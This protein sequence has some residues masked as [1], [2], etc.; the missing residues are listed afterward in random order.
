[1][2]N[3]RKFSE[4]IALHT[5][6]QAEETAR[7]EQIMKEVSDATA[8]VA[9]DRSSSKNTLRINTQTLG[10]FRGGSLP[11]VSAGVSTVKSASHNTESTKDEATTANMVNYRP[12]SRA[13]S[14]GGPIRRPHDRRLDTS[15]Y[16]SNSFLSPPHDTSWRRTH[17][18][19]ALHQSAM[20]DMNS[21][22]NDSCN[23]RWIM[24]NMN[25]PE[26]NE[27]RPRSSCEVPRVPG[28]HIYPSAHVPGAVQIPIS[29]NNTGSLP[30]LT[31]VNFSSP[32]RVPLDQDADQGSSPYSSSPVNTSP[33][34]LSPTSI[35]Q[36]VR[37][38]RFHFTHVSHAHS[39]HLSVP[40]YANHLNKNVPVNN[41]SIAGL[42]DGTD[43]TQLTG[44][45]G[46]YQQ[47]CPP[48]SPS[49]TLP[50]AS[51]YRSPRPSPQSS[52][53]LGGRHSAPCSPGAPSP[54]PNDYNNIFNQHQANQFQ[55]H[56][57]QLSMDWAQL[58]ASLLESGC[59]WS[60]Q[61]QLDPPVSSV[62]YVDQSPGQLTATHAQTVPEVSTVGSIELTSDPGYYSTSPSQLVYP[63]SL[64]TT[65]NTPTSIPDI[66]LTDFSSATDD[67]S[68][69]DLSKQLENDF[70]SEESLRESLDPLNFDELQMLT[71]PSMNFI[72]DGV[73]DGFRLHR[74]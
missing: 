20:Q 47:Q 32:I 12:G 21:E 68:R 59:T 70:F 61:L 40:R 11:N 33:S 16:S 14:Q 53:S 18:D 1:M 39:N 26:R 2:A 51:G 56:F 37:Q 43:L 17:S 64:H 30:D 60:A 69:Q 41:K 15:P 7:F 42:V 23:S 57:E 58:V 73:E 46:M 35:P 52:P 49:P 3:P 48:T 19:S 34:T 10:T 45:Q 6:R 13:R 28:I 9:P 38:G 67:I 25:G 5:H 72:P 8:R 62:S 74:S 65:P 50:Q 55:Q 27:G 31:N 22:R 54:L 66:I 44:I 71:D 24:P 4:K 36:G 63:P 29:G